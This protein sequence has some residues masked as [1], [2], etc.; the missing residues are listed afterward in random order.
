LV[1]GRLA[2]RGLLTPGPEWYE[3]RPILISQND[4]QLDLW[5]GDVGVIA[6]RDEQL[7]AF[8]AGTGASPGL[9]SFL[10]ARLPP[11]E[12]VFAMTVHKS[13][14]SE[15]DRVALLIPE[16]TSPFL[17]RELI[18]TAVSRARHRVE[19]YG[20]R[21][22]LRAALGRRVERASGLSAMLARHEPE[23]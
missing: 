3:G 14:G 6:R 17:T 9:R 11:H 10:P 1:V 16:K 5:N 8:F 12:T 7:Y 22:V 4:Y 13:Q 19:I 18:Y 15:F 20:T 2:R 23:P 21:A